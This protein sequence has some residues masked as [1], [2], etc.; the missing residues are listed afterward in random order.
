MRIS[1]WLFGFV[2]LGF[3]SACTDETSQLYHTPFP[4]TLST[5]MLTETPSAVSIS[6]TP[7]TTITHLSPI[8]SPS[9]SP[10]LT[11]ISPSPSPQPP[12]A[13]AL[14]PPAARPSITPPVPAN[15]PAFAG[16][17]GLWFVTDN[18]GQVQMM[19]AGEEEE[20]VPGTLVRSPDGTKL[21]WLA[22]SA[23]EQ[24][25]ARAERRNVRQAYP[26]VFDLT[27][28]SFTRYRDAPA[29][30]QSGLAW[31]A[32]GTALYLRPFHAAPD[33]QA[34]LYRLALAT[35]Q[36]EKAATVGENGDVLLGD[37]VMGPDNTLLFALVTAASSNQGS[38]LSLASLDP[39]SGRREILVE[40]MNAAHWDEETLW[41]ARLPFA[42]SP[43]G[44][45]IAFTIGHQLDPNMR[46]VEAQGLY[47]FAYGDETP[48]HIMAEPGL[49]TPLFSPD[50]RRVA[51]AGGLG[52]GNALL[53]Y[54]LESAQITSLTEAKLEQIKQTAN[55]EER[56]L[57]FLSIS[58][59]VWLDNQRL[60]LKI[61][62]AFP[63][64]PA[65]I[66][67]MTRIMKVVSGEIE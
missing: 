44:E 31:S 16:G 64:N 28:G 17:D 51:V 27:A 59:A 38:A 52:E 55:P 13:T 8:I 43:G 21:A 36:V 60:L 42:L 41:G 34:D 33:S 39:D 5:V 6:P 40:I 61:T 18:E 14:S 11:I 67:R 35:G 3:L 10:S 48:R 26:V 2:L 53:I 49:G 25:A 46:R 24:A 32:S 19:P 20:I 4:P 65:T 66:H 63:D 56:P 1:I 57:T 7:S 37:F 54:E 62:F 12:P 50:G 29:A 45:Q 23:A 47:L 58:P 22:V 9:P 30:R 15:A